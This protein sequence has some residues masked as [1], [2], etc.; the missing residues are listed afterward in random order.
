MVPISSLHDLGSRTSLATGLPRLV[1]TIPS[2]GMSSSRWRHC[3]RKSLA[4]KLFTYQLYM[5][6][7]IF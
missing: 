4:L 3:C 1:M 7:Y 2:E 5:H 6:M